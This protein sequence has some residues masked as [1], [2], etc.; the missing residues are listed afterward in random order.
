MLTNADQ[1]TRLVDRKWFNALWFQTTWFCVVLGRDD[2]LV[3]TVCLLAV[4]LL[5]V[6]AEA[7]ELRL[8]ALVGGMGMAVDAVLSATGIYQFDGDILVPLW[9]C[10][11]WLAFA[12]TT[13]RSLSFLGSSPFLTAAAGAIFIPLNYWA[14]QRLGAV[15]FGLPLLT[16]LLIV[17]A[18]WAVMLPVLY[19]LRPGLSTTETRGLLV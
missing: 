4:H 9:L 8:L 2:F 7:A 5:L 1:Q 14:G 10:A 3:V 15:E 17:S 12:T 18:S 19:L 13:T 11:L 16:T 6:K